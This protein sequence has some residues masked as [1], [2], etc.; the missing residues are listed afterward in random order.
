MSAIL[1]IAI[2]ASSLALSITAFGSSQELVLD[3]KK[4]ATISG[5]D[6]LVW[7]YYTPVVSAQSIMLK[8]AL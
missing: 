2:V 1:V 6:D 3:V 5:A 7:F 8:A 4:S